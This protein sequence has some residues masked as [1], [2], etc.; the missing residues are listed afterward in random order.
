MVMSRRPKF[1]VFRAWVR[2]S[3]SR[4]TNGDSL[5]PHS[6]PVKDEEERQANLK[7]AVFFAVVAW[8]LAPAYHLGHVQDRKNANLVADATALVRLTLPPPQRA[9]SRAAFS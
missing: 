5:R 9:V 1:S 6:V 2:P 7:L 4:Q 8:L 3:P